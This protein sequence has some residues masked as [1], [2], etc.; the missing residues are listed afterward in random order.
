[1]AVGEAVHLPA[2]AAAAV[3]AVAATATTAIRWVPRLC[4]GT[5]PPLQGDAPLRGPATGP[6][7]AGEAVAAAAAALAPAVAGC[8][9]G[10]LTMADRE[11]LAANI[12]AVVANDRWHAPATPRES[13]HCYVL[14]C[15]FPGVQWSLCHTSHAYCLFTTW[16]HHLQPL[17]VPND[18]VAGIAASSL[19]T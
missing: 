6:S 17:A 11:R 16:P 14:F 15:C 9:V 5:A 13:R 2:A 7:A 8:S 1:M 10:L 4:D 12:A 3:A 18:P 19:V